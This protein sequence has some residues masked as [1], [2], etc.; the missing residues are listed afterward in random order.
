MKNNYIRNS[1]L[2]FVSLFLLVVMYSCANMAS[3]NGGP[4]D[5][6]APKFVRSTPAPNQTNFKGKKVEIEFDELVQL[7]KPMDN[8]IVTPPQLQLPVIKSAGKKV[9]VELKDTLKANTTYTIDFT[10]SISDNN[11]K[12]IVENFSFAFSTGKNI[13]SL[14]VAGT[15]LNAENLEPMPGVTIGLHANLDDSAFVKI[16]FERT[17]RTNERGQ[18]TI[19][20]IATGT[21]RLFALNDVNRDYK[22][23]QAGED[24]AFLDSLVV[25]TFEFAT[26][27]DTIWKDTLT[28]DTIKTVGYT[29]FLPDD[30]A[31]RLFKEKFVRQY[32]LKPERLQ[33]NKL[34]L[35]FNAPLDSIPVPRPLNFEAKD[36]D[37]YFVQQA[38]ENKTVNYWLTDSM[39]WK[40]DTLSFEIQY[41]KSDSLNILRPQTDTLQLVIR[42]RPEPKAK[43]KKKKNE[44]EPIVFLNMSIDAPGQMDI[45]DTVTVTFDE[46]LLDLK[47]EMFYLDIK[48]DTLWENVDFDFFRDSLNTLTYNINRKWKYG[49]T[50]RLEVDSAIIHSIYGKWNDNYTGEF[51]IKKEEDYGNL[52]IAIS[53]VNLD[54][55]AFV[56]L[57]DKSDAV[58]RKAPVKDGGVLFFDLKPDKYYARIIMDKNGNNKWDTG[59]YAEKLQ[60]EEVFYYPNYFTVLQFFNGEESWDVSSTPLN[61]QKPLDITKNKPKETT[62]KKRNYKDEGKTSGSSSSGMRMPGF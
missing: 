17:S 7:D 45:F 30:V 50:Y 41:P 14:E 6:A 60:P 38:D 15:L 5:E 20:N 22:F 27:Q 18:F 10:N 39:V 3:P 13:D 35:R 34:T 25:P 61:K 12:N 29:H 37:W 51:T 59:N 21:Y 1:V 33:E 62:K 36:N 53:G 43:K 55:P 47:K 4:Y 57:L 46:P 23:D 49:E 52:Y 54:T 11:E 28:V 31:L 44:P 24:I 16:P 56:E 9:I 8:V 2:A 26:R 40:Q 58:V 19:R 48:K 42:R 32:M